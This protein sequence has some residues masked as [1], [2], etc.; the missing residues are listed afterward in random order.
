MLC[1]GGSDTCRRR[2]SAMH[3]GAAARVGFKIRALFLQMRVSQISED[4]KSP[5]QSAYMP[6]FFFE[7]V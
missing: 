6:L 4:G 3:D 2:R 5:M 7:Y 1:S